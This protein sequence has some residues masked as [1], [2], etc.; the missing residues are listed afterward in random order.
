MRKYKVIDFEQFLNQ[1]N[2]IEYKPKTYNLWRDGMITGIDKI[3]GQVLIVDALNEDVSDWY[4]IYQ[5]NDV[6]KP[7]VRFKNQL[8]D[9]RPLSTGVVERDQIKD[10]TYITIFINEQ[11]HDHKI[12]RDENGTLR[13]KENPSVRKAID[14]KRVDLNELL[15]LFHHLGY[16]KNSE[17][18]RKLYRDM[19]YSLY[20]YWEIFYWEVNNPKAGKYRPNAK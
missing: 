8:E 16:D 12:I 2:K 3:R 10:H 11:H 4:S 20:G 15:V 6:N 17:V 7:I 18:Y 13:W 19:G 1:R 5:A 14:T 9:I